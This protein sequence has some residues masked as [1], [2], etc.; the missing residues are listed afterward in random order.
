[1]LAPHRIV[2]ILVSLY[3]VLHCYLMLWPLKELSKTGSCR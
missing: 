2:E 1:M 3:H